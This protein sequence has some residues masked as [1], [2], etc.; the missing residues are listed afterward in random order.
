MSTKTHSLSTSGLSMSQ[1]ASISNNLNQRAS[2]IQSRIDAINNASKTVNVNGTTYISQNA[3]PIPNN[4]IDLILEKG[5]LHACQAFLMENIKA[6]ESLLLAAKQ[7]KYWNQAP[8]PKYPEQAAPNLI[9]LVNEDWGWSQL[10]KKEMSEYLYIESRA[11]HIGQFIHEKGKL[12]QL[13]NELPKL[14]GLEW[15]SIETGKQ[16]P[17]SVSKHH[18]P[19]QLMAVYELLSKLHGEANQKVNYF[20]AKINNL[21]TN[22]NARIAKQNAIEIN[23]VEV[24]NSSAREQYKIDNDAY[25]SREHAE[26]AEFESRKHTAISKIAA[27]KIEVSPIFQDTITSVLN[28]TGEDILEA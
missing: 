25:S 7:S 5:T 19:E 15:M 17:V 13:R 23:R 18:T 10:T 9:Q 4:I 14:S 3:H 22:E 26:I 2:E 1:A 24:L 28:K 6:K 16:T 8:S 20:K 27:L 11:A 12:S 21:V